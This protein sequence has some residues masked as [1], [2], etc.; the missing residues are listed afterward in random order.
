[1]EIQQIVFEML[2]SSSNRKKDVSKQLDPTSRQD[3]PL[4]PA[5]QKASLGKL[6]FIGV[7][8]AATAIA[9]HVTPVDVFALHNVYQRLYYLPIFA[10]AH[11]FGLRGA[12]AASLLSAASYFPHIFMDWGGLH[13][14]HDEYLQAQ[15]AELFMF[16]VVAVVVG[17][18]AESERRSHD[19]QERTALELAEAYEKLRESFEQLLRADRL[20]SLGELSAGLAHEIKNPLASIKASLEILFTEL[21][22]DREKREFA[23]IVEKELNHLENIVDEFLQFARTPKPVRE[24]CD[25]G[26]VVASL[27]TLCSQEAQ[28]HAVVLDI[29]IPRTLPEI[30]VDASQVQQA[31]LN[32]VLNGIQA[33]PSGGS[34]EIEIEGRPGGVVTRVHDQGP[35]IDPDDTARIFEPFFTTKARGTGLGLAIARKLI[36]AQGGE[37]RLASHGSGG[38]IFVIDLPDKGGR[39]G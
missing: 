33:M 25:L 26:D 1:M 18:L 32:V 24:P 10:A 13:G 8:I 30:E 38:S 9:H 34:L 37:I 23:E 14:V 28:R 35:G 19:R 15:Y 39:D 5:R 2:Q 6:T 22:L 3:T 7:A 31:L 17:A 12:V 16:Q 11:W 4:V 36:E 21:P 27:K 29:S 20:T